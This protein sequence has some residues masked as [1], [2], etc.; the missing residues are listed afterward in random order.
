MRQSCVLNVIHIKH[1]LF[2]K[3]NKK[4]YE[5]ASPFPRSR[6]TKRFSKPLGPQF[7]THENIAFIFRIKIKDKKMK[8]QI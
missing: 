1:G 7:L 4:N 8:Q 3:V 5:L 6:R 2:A